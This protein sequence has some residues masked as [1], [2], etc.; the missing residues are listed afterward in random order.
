MA[1]AELKTKDVGQVASFPHPQYMVVVLESAA[2]DDNKT[3][4]ISWTLKAGPCS[5]ASNSVKFNNI[6]LAINGDVVYSGSKTCTANTVIATGTVTVEHN[7]DGSKTVDVSASATIYSAAGQSDFT[8]TFTLDKL[9]TA[10]GLIYIDD[11]K[12]VAPYQCY[13][14][15]GSSW[16]LYFPYL[17]NGSE[18]ET[19]K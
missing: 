12:T 15:N 14:D 19:C 13:I 1:Y 10:M 9:A 3:S 17:D 16:D 11:G 8:G 18:W 4:V 5:Y 7:A 6:S 2:N